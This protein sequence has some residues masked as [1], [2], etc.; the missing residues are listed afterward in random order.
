MPPRAQLISRT[1]GRRCSQLRHADQVAGFVGQRRVH[2]QVIDLRQHVGHGGG[3]ARCPAPGCARVDRNGSK[4]STRICK[5]L[6]PRGDG[7]AD[8]AQADDAQRLVG[9]LRAHVLVAVPLAFDQALIGRRDVARQGQHHGDRV[10]GRA[11]RVAGRRVHHHDAQPGGGLRVDV[12]GADAG[13]DDGLEPMIALQ[14]V[15]R[16]LHAAAADRAVELGQRRR[17]A[18]RPSGRCELRYSIPLAAASRSR[19]SWANV[20]NTITFGMITLGVFN[21]VSDKRAR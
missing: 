5:R 6:G 7:L 9:Q 11:Q 1:P 12:V 18:R 21:N 13:A 15:G 4:P 14:H 20:S 16:D 19:P 2:G 17:A 10:L 3:T 8:A